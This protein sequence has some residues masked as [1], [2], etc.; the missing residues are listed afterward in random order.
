[1]RYF[2]TIVALIVVSIELSSES[3]VKIRTRRQIEREGNLNETTTVFAGEREPTD[4][5]FEVVPVDDKTDV[6]EVDYDPDDGT[7]QFGGKFPTFF[8]KHFNTN[9]DDLFRQMTRRFEDMTRSMFERFNAT[10]SLYP[11]NYNGTKEEIVT[12]DGK[13][14]IKKEHV[15]K[16]SDDG[17]NIFLTTTT[18]EPV[19]DKTN[20]T[21]NDIPSV[22]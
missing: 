12:I 1:M 20:E 16:K 8:H 14:Y 18:Y 2:V 4:K 6:M 3:K 13:Q 19:D 5:D 10:S 17:L 21:P 7:F 22:Q 11:A 9:F 15:I